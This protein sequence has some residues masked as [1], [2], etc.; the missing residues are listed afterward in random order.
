MTEE[1]TSSTITFAQ[2]HCGG[3]ESEV[4]IF[5]SGFIPTYNPIICT[6]GKPE[7][8]KELVGN[9]ENL[10]GVCLAVSEPRPR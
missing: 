7:T 3:D 2:Y 4:K 8:M 5:I 1:L 9:L 6:K 10:L